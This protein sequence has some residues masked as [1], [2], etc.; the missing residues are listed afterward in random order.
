M[1]QQ[2]SYRTVK[3][4]GLSIPVAVRAFPN[5]IYQAPRSW[6][7][8]AYQTDYYGRLPKGGHFVA[9]EQPELQSIFLPL[10]GVSPFAIC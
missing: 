9:W 10:Q 8:K 3:V 2:M 6:T 1:E 5:E 4:D 7:E